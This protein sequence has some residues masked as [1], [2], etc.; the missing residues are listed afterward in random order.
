MKLVLEQ[1]YLFA[2][3]VGPA[4]AHAFGGDAHNHHHTGADGWGAGESHTDHGAA[5]PT[6]PAIGEP[7][8]G[9]SGSPETV[10]FVDPRVA[11]WQELVAGAKPGVDVV[12]LDPNQDGI[13][14]VTQALAGLTNVRNIEFLTDGTPGSITLGGTTLDA[15]VLGARANEITG[16]SAHLAANADIVF[17]GCDVGQGSV[18][19]TFVSDVH[20]LTGATVGA[21][22]DATGAAGLGGDWTLE[23]STGPLHR[24]INPFTKDTLASY[25]GVL[26]TPQPSVA[27]AVTDNGV[28]DGGTL[29][30]G[31]TITTTIAFGNTAEN[32]TGYTPYVE[33]FVPNGLTLSGSAT[34][35]GT[36]L[37][38]LTATVSGGMVINPLT[39]QS[40]LAPTGF[41]N[42]TMYVFETP[43]GTSLAAGALLSPIVAN[44][45][46]SSDVSLV[47]EALMIA[48][49]GGFADGPTS[50]SGENVEGDTFTSTATVVQPLDPAI[51]IIGTSNDTQGLG[52]ATD[53]VSGNGDV[54]FNSNGTSS[55]SPV[56]VEP[57]EIVRMRVIDQLATTGTNDSVSFT[58]TLPTGMT[59]DSNYATDNSVTIGLVSSNGSTSTSATLTQG[60][61]SANLQITNGSVNVNN[62]DLGPGSGTDPVLATLANAT[63]AP[64]GSSITFNLGN[65][66]NSSATALY[67]VVEFNAVINSSAINGTALQPTLSIPGAVTTTALQTVSTPMLG[68]G[69]ALTDI[70]DVLSLPTFNDLLGTLDSMTL[71]L[72]GQLASSG[73]I[74][75][76]SG[77][78]QTVSQL[79]V[80]SALKL[81]QASGGPALPGNVT[82]SKSLNVS[83]NYNGGTTVDAGVTLSFAPIPG[84]VSQPVSGATQ[85]TF[86]TP[87]L[88]TS[89]E[90]SG[91]GTVPIKATTTTTVAIS[92]SGGNIN[93]S[94]AT[95]A[96]VTAAVQYTY[97][98][99]SVS[100]T[101][102]LMVE[103]PTVT[104][105]K[106]I[107][108]VSY[109]GTTATVT[110]VDTVSNTSTDV[111]AYGLTLTDTGDGN[112]SVAAD[113]I[114]YVSDSGGQPVTSVGIVG[115]QLQATFSS[116]PANGTETFTYTE[117]VPIADV[118]A[119][120]ASSKT[121]Q[122]TVTSFD[123][124]PAL[125]NPTNN[126][127]TGK[128]VL[129]GTS[130]T[131]PTYTVTATAP[132]DSISGTVNQDTGGTEFALSS[133]SPLS[134]ETVTVSYT[135]QTATESLQTDSSGDFTLLVPDGLSAVTLSAAVAGTLSTAVLDNHPSDTGTPSPLPLSSTATETGYGTSNTGA[136][137][138]N[139]V[140]GSSYSGI[141]FDFWQ[142]ATT[143][144]TP[145]AQL[146]IVGGSNDTAGL[147]TQFDPNG[148]TSPGVLMTDG[149]IVRERAT[150]DLTA[151]TAN[152][153]S[154]TVTLPSDLTLDPNYATDGSVT[155]L[156]VST[157]GSVSTS[158][159]GSGLQLADASPDASKLNLGN[160]PDTTDPVTTALPV[161][162]IGVSGSTVTFNLGNLKDL[163][164]SYQAI[165]EFN[166]IV[167]ATAATGTVLNTQMG[168]SV[169]PVNTANANDYVNTQAP[170]VG[171]TK[172]ITGISY[173]GSTATVTYV[174][175]VS[176]SSGVT[177]YNLSLNDVGDGNNPSDTIG[178]VTDG[179]SGVGNVT[180][181]G[182]ASN[183]LA[184][185]ISSLADGKSVTF[186][187]TEQIPS[188]DVATSVADSQ[189][190]QA[191]VNW[192]ALTN[193]TETLVHT[194]VTATTSDVTAKAPL[195]VVS[196]TVN[197]DT[198]STFGGG[199]GT[200]GDLT[201]L[202]GQ[203]IALTF[204]GQS[205]TE[206]T[207]TDS[208]GDFSLLAPTGDAVTITVTPTGP[209]APL[210]PAEQMDNTPST[211]GTP[212]LPSASDNHTTQG[213][214]GAGTLTFTPGAASYSGVTFDFWSTPDTAPVLAHG[215]SSPDTYVAGGSGITLFPAGTVAD[216]E[217]DTDFAHDFSGTT[218]TMERYVGGVATPN[219]ND[220]FTGSGTSTTG[221]FLNT[222]NHEVFLNGTEV[223]TFTETGGKLSITF[224][225]TGITNTTVDTVWQGINY[226]YTGTL[227][228]TITG[229]VIGTQ[230]DDA[231]NDPISVGG[232]PLDPAGPHDQGVGGDL[233]SNVLTATLTLL[234][235][236]T[237]TPE[238][239]VVGGSNETANPTPLF[240][241]SGQTSPGVAMTDG[242]IV[243]ERA[244]LDLT[245]GSSANTS[246]T[247]TL[248]SDLT[249]DPNYATDGSVTVL[250]VSTDGSV[251][252][253]LTG[254]GL[255][256]TDA[257]PNGGKLD[258]AT[259]ADTTDPVTTVLPNSDISYNPI[260]HT[261][262]FDLHNLSDAAGSYQAIVEFNA[263]VSPTAATGTVLNTQMTGSANG[264]TTATVNDYVD[265]QAPAVALTKTITGFSTSG[266]T[267][268]V[269]Y[270][271]TITNTSGVAA[272]YGLTL[273]DAGD[274]NASDT[275]TD[276]N[277][278]SGTGTGVSSSVVDGNFVATLTSLSANGTE[279]FTYT[280]T[281]PAADLATSMADSKTAQATVT[282]FDLNPAQFSPANNLTTGK[283]VLAGTSETPPIHSVSKMAPFSLVSGT[284]NQDTS[285][286][287]GGLTPLN[288]LPN[289]TVVITFTGGSETVQT[290]SNGHFTA[291]IP[292]V[293]VSITPTVDPSLVLDNHPDTTGTP[294]LPSAGTTGFESSN[295]PTLTFNPAPGI[296]YTGVT[297][298]FW[299]ST[300]QLPPVF[301]N[302]VTPAVSI[303]EIPEI[304]QLALIGS[305]DNRFIIEDQQT[306]IQVP[307]DIFIDSDPNAQLEYD[308]MLPD[309]TPLPSWLHFDPNNLTFEG[310][311]PLY[312][313]GRIEITITA[314]DQYGNMAEASFSI[315]VGQKE[316]DL[317]KLLLQSNLQPGTFRPY[318]FQFDLQVSE[319]T[320]VPPPPGSQPGRQ[321]IQI[322]DAAALH[323]REALHRAEAWSAAP[324]V[325]QAG[326]FGG[327]TAALRKAG[328]IGALGRARALLDGLDKLPHARSSI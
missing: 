78:T 77:A 300:S 248:P 190:A 111:A 296:S 267:T 9:R 291:L 242:E 51:S 281:V 133:L 208:L 231:N 15:A 316:E 41:A 100:G 246:M 166:A 294:G 311:P 221:V 99:P 45:T 91:A 114:Q 34:E 24:D 223:G 123:L 59:F 284:V 115:N 154:I 31:D 167:S 245:D 144:S 145:T 285:P 292:D 72:N 198:A 158:L 27:L 48:A 63:I 143:S 252:T 36:A 169:G 75:N 131:P 264:N 179:G 160:A 257:S 326:D 10:L 229:V 147:G 148:L 170:A 247:V 44:F 35:N 265:P 236:S 69:G 235:Q 277:S 4:V 225:S 165:V 260:T 67:V 5:R 23:V 259:G 12:M 95:Y 92:D 295:A 286:T 180:S 177:A 226:S 241:P 209:E 117:T 136:F 270:V 164:G 105:A 159:T 74:T 266:T 178:Y 312:S 124:N 149:E 184:A 182:I 188:T 274:G 161:S 202:S 222:T 103:A 104:L 325:T 109:S 13:S 128:E 302:N 175:T 152:S 60:H 280:E 163:S 140:S 313:R 320:P 318:G 304:P 279:T 42:G 101:A 121:A 239:S 32:A 323:L 90:T 19:T 129:A 70:S 119:S 293:P 157:D 26:D 65:I 299:K 319:A 305:V 278:H 49:R 297:F 86:S 232:A 210:P 62:L 263:I 106:A 309:G 310:T 156:L 135:G 220:R 132:F 112:N 315:L 126:L 290:D 217:L 11:D 288:P 73:T 50:G 142:A 194:T 212:S 214:P 233:L 39:H 113:T 80:S 234:P 162:D 206:T 203:S 271:D 46:M 186:T 57:G 298:D 230:I 268:T 16:W 139:P 155:V 211:T 192:Q 201:S 94:V 151:G 219:A 317:G 196:G 53:T 20:T 150:L 61:D 244:T 83:Q 258:L 37:T 181:V 130:E 308:A 8:V 243:R 110:Y 54:L 64:S 137:S 138:F 33:V 84:S 47:G 3:D 213:N 125:F 134:G 28:T 283:E 261:V 153:S 85:Q 2:G 253:S 107:T 215:P 218:L 224:L 269:T 174:D 22:S 18:G 207:A 191:Q 205:G 97:T 102:Y 58:V 81:G 321:P 185:S 17:W 314:K 272:A 303:S 327:F 187:Y 307:P 89:F 76:N 238:L 276:P 40:E 173:S 108:G 197:Q 227:T 172:A 66:T 56:S 171:L 146:S 1:R 255:Q 88:L 7:H 79:T 324:Q 141:A 93:D 250:L 120:V 289:E 204:A 199:V 68:T 55:G 122:A 216:T 25:S 282:S 30:L 251:S 262:T 87:S 183:A 127:T 82:L 29:N 240:D 168:A 301:S 306:V 38:D 237:A 52:T 21:S 228:S 6:P 116:L 71:T 328:H 273:T 249:L 189:T 256:L 193:S 322:A 195:S 200:P 98:P 118:A 96:E 275:I 43:S 14:Q 287:E 176:N 254:S